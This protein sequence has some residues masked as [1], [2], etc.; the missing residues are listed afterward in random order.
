MTA[1]IHDNRCSYPLC[2][3]WAVQTIHKELPFKNI[4]R[5]YHLCDRHLL[6][7]LKDYQEVYQIEPELVSVDVQE[8]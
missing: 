8:K 6:V 4:R 3:R 1:E 7:W 5:T 2:R